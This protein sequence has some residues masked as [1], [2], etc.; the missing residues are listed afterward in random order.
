[1]SM[2]TIYC[3]HRYKNHPLKIYLRVELNAARL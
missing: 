2:F 1:M 3:A